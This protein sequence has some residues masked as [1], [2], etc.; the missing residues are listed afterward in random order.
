MAYLEVIKNG[1][2]V[3]RRPIDDGQARNGY[4][5]RIGSANE[6]RLTLGESKQIGDY[7]IKMCEG[8]APGPRDKAAGIPTGVPDSFPAVSATGRTETGT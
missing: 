3:E 8:V 1:K 4:R 7:E 2:L 6:I 5:I